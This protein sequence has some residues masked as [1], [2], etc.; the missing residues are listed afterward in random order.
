[1]SGVSECMGQRHKDTGA[2]EVRASVAESQP[3]NAGAGYQTGDAAHT[4]YLPEVH[5]RPWRGKFLGF[6]SSSAQHDRLVK[7]LDSRL[8]KES[9]ANKGSVNILQQKDRVAHI[10]QSANPSG[11]WASNPKRNSQNPRGFE[12]RL[13]FVRIRYGLSSQEAGAQGRSSRQATSRIP[14]KLLTGSK[15]FCLFR[16]RNRT[17]NPSP[18]R[19]CL[20][21]QLGNY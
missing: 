16:C 19:D 13:V 17:Q 18:R 5:E 12:A 3:C 7:T 21:G 2:L 6:V 1:M 11:T 4:V 14:G 15:P 10:Q 20:A 8:G 9:K